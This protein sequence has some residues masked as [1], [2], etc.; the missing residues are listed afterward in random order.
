MPGGFFK[1]FRPLNHPPR[2][3]EI[4]EALMLSVLDGM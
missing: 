2:I 4:D 1:P 3:K